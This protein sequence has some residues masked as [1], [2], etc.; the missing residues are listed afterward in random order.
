MINQLSNYMKYIQ[1]YLRKSLSLC[2]LFSAC[3]QALSAQHRTTNAQP[4]DD[5]WLV[6][7][8]A[9]LQEIATHGDEIDLVFIG[10]SI[11]HFMDDRAPGL[12]ERT[13]PGMPHLNLGYSA[14]R[15]ENVL[16]RLQNGEIDGISPKVVVLMIGTNNTGH[17]RDPA[18]ETLGGI[19]LI[20]ETLQR[21]LPESK[22]LLLSIFPRGASAGD[23]LRQLNEQINAELPRL[24][25]GQTVFYQNIN[26]AFLDAEGRLPKDVMPDLLHPNRK[27]YELWL[28]A[29]QPKVQQLL[30]RQQLPT[31]PEVWSHYDPDSGDFNEEII[32]EETKDGIYYKESYISAYVNGEEVRVYCKYAVKASVSNAP[33]LMDVHGWMAGPR[34]DMSYVNDGWAV[35]SHDYSGI[36][37]RPHYTKYPEP[38]AHGHMDARRMGHSLIY[39]RMPDGSQLTDPKAT[40]HYLWNAIQRRVLSY[41]LAQKEVDASRIGAKGYSYGGT[42]MWNMAMDPRVKAVVA[43]FGIGW[44]EYYRNRAVWKYNQPIKAPDT[45]PGEAL[46]LSALAP[47]AH[48]PY[49][50]AASLWLNGSNDHHGGHERACDTFT[51]FKPEVPWDFAVQARGHHNVE[52]LGNDC[53][54]WL[55]KHVLG[56]EHFWPARSVSVLR[57]GSDGVPELHVTPANPE[58]IKQLQVYQCL[59][60]ANN[61]ERYWR[62]VK[63]VRKGNTWVAKLPVM[64]VDDYVFS[65]ANIHYENDCVVSSDF[66]AVIPSHLGN[67]VATDTKADALPGGADRWSHAA[68]AEGVG[69]IEGF[70]PIDN[71]RGTSS[72]Q[73]ADPKWR[74]PEG[75]ELSFKFYCTQPQTLILNA[76][77]ASAEIEITASDEWQSMTIPASQ[78]K[79]SNGAALGDWAQVKRIGFKPKA[80]SDITKVIF[81]DFEWKGAAGKAIQS[82]QSLKLG[83]DGKAYLTKEAASF[84]ESFWRVMNDQGVE[85][86]AISVGGKQFERGLGVHSDSRISFALN[87]QF[88]AFHVVPGPDDAHK[89]LLEMSIL[90]D[91]KE[92]FASGKVSSSRFVAKPITI[93]VT[94]AK[95]LTLVVTDGGDG[96]GGDHA[97]WADAYLK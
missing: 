3:F 54:L 79:Q 5:W 60:T 38:L 81:A 26:D 1:Q 42:I 50:N 44:I 91:G 8:E 56:K 12:V 67:A 15:T 68:P 11:T 43:H 63:S 69:G 28:A 16:W 7:H 73:F 70:R 97:S 24:A 96:P 75:A 41:L 6:R 80:G 9:K 25:D 86:K 21:Q 93:P 52:K 33:G 10:D 19:R 89:G 77:R 49:I 39:S 48:A 30:A 31:P 22:V 85:G 23:P 59:N 32:K 40:S 64:N 53:K 51:R 27:G 87:G 71:R 20:V 90:I 65:Y 72:E 17:R 92:V 62:D 2:I 84:I 45:T 57:L 95:E 18:A 61:I 46:F 13:F 83:K 94:G 74:A 58:R 78:L 55:E 88:T 35:M 36:T 76:G 14:D 82:S 4:R 66:E 37:S 47:Q 34:P 29:I